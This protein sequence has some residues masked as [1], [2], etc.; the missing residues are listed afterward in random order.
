[1][2]EGAVGGVVWRDFAYQNNY[3]NAVDRGGYEDL[4]PF[5]FEGSACHQSLQKFKRDVAEGGA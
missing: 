4:G 5:F 3:E 1:V 2:I